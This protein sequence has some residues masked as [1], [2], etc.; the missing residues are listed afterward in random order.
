M[1]KLKHFIYE[2]SYKGNIGFSEMAMFYQ[3][4]S[5]TEISQ[6]EKIIKSED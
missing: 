5:N 2:K 3:K 1:N 4:A 6:M